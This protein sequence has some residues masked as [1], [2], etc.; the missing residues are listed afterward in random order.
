MKTVSLLG[1]QPLL[2]SWLCRELADTWA[3]GIIHDIHLTGIPGSFKADCFVIRT[4]NE[5]ETKQAGTFLKLNPGIPALAWWSARTI[6][7]HET[8]S[9]LKAGFSGILTEI[10]DPSDLAFAVNDLLE[11]G[12]HFNSAA[13]SAIFHHFHKMNTSGKFPLSDREHKAIQFRKTG[14]TSKEIAAELFLSKKTVDKLFCDLY[15]KAGCGN[16][17]ELLGRLENYSN[18]MG[19]KMD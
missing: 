19:Y 11:K 14:L 5:H 8:I 3:Y 12:V 16:F 4:G 17:F 15:R 6:S 2:V 9:L 13:G 18:A 1:F 10:H 7:E